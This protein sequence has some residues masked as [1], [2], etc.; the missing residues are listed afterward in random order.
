MKKVLLVVSI[1]SIAIAAVVL[2]CRKSGNAHDGNVNKKSTTNE[3]ASRMAGGSVCQCAVGQI[4]CQ[5]NCWLSDCCVCW[6]PLTSDGGC[7]CWLGVALCKVESRKKDAAVYATRVKVYENRILEL[8]DYLDKISINTNGL[9][10]K[11]TVV[12]AKSALFGKQE[13]KDNFRML[14]GVD[15]SSFAEY[16]KEYTKGLKQEDQNKVSEFIEFKKSGVSK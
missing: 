7:G 5:S 8:F 1:L 13:S 15:Y 14:P 11:Y 2:S 16:Y 12:S 3:V 6:N 10:S 4:S 9:R